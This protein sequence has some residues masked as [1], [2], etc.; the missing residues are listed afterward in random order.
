MKITAEKLV[1]VIGISLITAAV[2][3]YLFREQRFYYLFTNDRGYVSRQEISPR[4]YYEYNRTN[5]QIIKVTHYNFEWSVL[6]FLFVCGLGM[7]SIVAKKGNPGLKRWVNKFFTHTSIL[8]TFT[9]AKKKFTIK[10][11]Q[12]SVSSQKLVLNDTLEN[13]TIRIEVKTNF[14]RTSAIYVVISNSR[15]NEILNLIN[16]GLTMREALIVTGDKKRRTSY[17]YGDVIGILFPP[18]NVFKLKLTPYILSEILKEENKLVQIHEAIIN[19]ALR[20][21]GLD[22]NL[23]NIGLLESSHNRDYEMNFD[24]FGEFIKHRIQ[25]IPEEE[26]LRIAHEN[27]AYT[28]AIKSLLSIRTSGGTPGRE[29]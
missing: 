13:K 14:L 24:E 12:P 1:F 4:D 10:R 5:K 7:I 20:E 9:L 17:L 22:P 27:N 6:S 15:H 19:V 2:M 25:G 18:S 29:R 26:A 11:G 8:E 21:K 16:S 23:F 3:G 28:D